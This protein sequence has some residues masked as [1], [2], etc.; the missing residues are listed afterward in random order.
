[1]KKPPEQ[2]VKNQTL[3]AFDVGSKRIG[4]ALWNPRIQL[5]SELPARNRKNLRSDL[6]F[7]KELFHKHEVSAVVIGWP[8]SLAGHYT[9][10]TERAEFWKNTIEKHFDCPVYCQD[11]SLSTRDAE[12][13]L[14]QRGLSSKRVKEHK[15]SLAALIILEDFL[16]E[17]EE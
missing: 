4:L 5:S 14:K 16:R 10:S 6:Q 15:D 1:M 7:F 9:P 17:H 11:E 12:T 8:L 13:I 3:L 2:G